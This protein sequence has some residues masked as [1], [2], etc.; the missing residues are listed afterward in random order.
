VIFLHL[1][2]D[3]KAQGSASSQGRQDL[4]LL[5]TEL[6][7]TV[8]AHKKRDWALDRCTMASMLHNQTCQQLNR[9]SVGYVCLFHS[10]YKD[11]IAHFLVPL[12]LISTGT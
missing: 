4:L 7:V 3:P 5:G 6:C 10:L 11:G 1:A 12:W 9:E 8:L 2:D